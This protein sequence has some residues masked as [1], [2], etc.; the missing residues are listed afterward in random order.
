MRAVDVAMVHQDERS[1]RNF[2]HSERT[3]RRAVTGPA[4]DE[5]VGV[6]IIDVVLIGLPPAM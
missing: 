4:M 6:V 1:E 2:V 3:R 5:V